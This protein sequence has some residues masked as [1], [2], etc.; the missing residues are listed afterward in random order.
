LPLRSP[1]HIVD[2]SREI[3]SPPDDYADGSWTE[4]LNTIQLEASSY[5]KKHRRK[6]SRRYYCYLG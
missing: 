3:P 2:S 4:W 5:I 6:I 1:A